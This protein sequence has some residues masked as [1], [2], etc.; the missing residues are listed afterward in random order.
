M[1][2]VEEGRP[3]KERLE[4]DEGG[5]NDPRSKLYVVLVEPVFGQQGVN[6]RILAYPCAVRPMRRQ[7]QAGERIAYSQ[8]FAC[9]AHRV[10][11]SLGRRR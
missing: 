9:V 5:L 1:V 10:R 3:A 4:G 8:S 7:D 6:V 2:M 11:L